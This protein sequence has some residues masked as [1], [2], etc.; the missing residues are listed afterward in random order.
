MQAYSAPRKP[1]ENPGKLANVFGVH[2]DVGNVRWITFQ[3]DLGNKSPLHH[4]FRK[5]VKPKKQHEVVR[6]ARIVKLLA[7]TSD[8]QQVVVLLSGNS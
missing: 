8:C 7:K 1:I 3:E 4:V 2:D 6:M 5:H